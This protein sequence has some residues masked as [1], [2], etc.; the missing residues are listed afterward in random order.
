MAEYRLTPAAERDLETIWT[1]KQYTCPPREFWIT[2]VMSGTAEGLLLYE[3]ASQL[4]N[5]L[6]AFVGRVPQVNIVN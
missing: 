3:A 6:L 4:P 2:G 5:F 1:H